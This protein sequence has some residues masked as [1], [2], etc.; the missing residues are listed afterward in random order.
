[1]TSQELGEV[2]WIRRQQY[3]GRVT[4]RLGGDESIDGVVP[5]G[6]GE[7]ATG[8]TCRWLVERIVRRRVGQHEVGPCISRPE[9]TCGLGDDD[10]RHAHL[11]P[12]VAQPFEPRDQVAISPGESDDCP[13]IEDN[14]SVISAAHCR[15]FVNSSSVRGP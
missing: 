11:P 1:M 7:Q 15:P 14:C 10:H 3:G 13:G 12:E 8:E 9:T 6:G 4:D 5:T 2:G